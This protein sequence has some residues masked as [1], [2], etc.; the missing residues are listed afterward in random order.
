MKL[1][2][3][4][5]I[6]VKNPRILTTLRTG[7]FGRGFYTTSSIK[8]AR[9]WAQIRARQAEINLGI[10]SIFEVADTIF[11]NPSL[12]V[13]TFTTAN[14]EWLDFVLAN[15]MDVAYEHQFDLVQGPV[16]N[17]RVYACLNALEEGLAER[18]TVLQRLK[19]F[20]LADQILFHTSQSLQFLNFAASEE[21]PC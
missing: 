19:T 20:V 1:Y 6:E 17:D 4:S 13:K 14:D 15:R 3:G 10:V 8:Q 9:R 12:S 5:N 21:V 18:A 2:H 7:D 16:A 11:E